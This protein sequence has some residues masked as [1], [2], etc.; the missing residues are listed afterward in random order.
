MA[1]LNKHCK[2]TIYFG[3]DDSG[4][5]NGQQIS[6]S[7]KKDISRM[8]SETVQPKISPTID[9]L[10]IDGKEIIRVSFSGYNRPYSISGKYL[11]RVE[12]KIE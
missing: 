8:I 9:T 7:T 11:T 3:V 6:D 2:E 4:F 1:I 10:V 5:I 12:P